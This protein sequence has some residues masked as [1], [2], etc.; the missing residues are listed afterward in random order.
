MAAGPFRGAIQVRVFE[1]DEAPE[2]EFDYIPSDDSAE[3]ICT[4]CRQCPAADDEVLC[5]GCLAPV[6]VE[7]RARPWPEPEQAYGP[8]D[9]EV[10]YLRP[11]AAGTWV[12]D[13]DVPTVTA[14]EAYRIVREKAVCP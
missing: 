2:Y 1:T 4:S 6:N 8:R 14:Q 7:G 9:G 12:R 5:W 3:P 13:F 10:W 11:T